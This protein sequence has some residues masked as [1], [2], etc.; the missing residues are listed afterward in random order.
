MHMWIPIA[1]TVLL[2]L[3]A[4]AWRNE[5]VY[6]Y[7]RDIINKVYEVSMADLALGKDPT[8]RVDAYDDGPSYGG[9]LSKFWKPLDSFYPDKSFLED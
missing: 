4:L 8:W 3:M 5:L 9:M 6:A 7:R 2:A 1:V